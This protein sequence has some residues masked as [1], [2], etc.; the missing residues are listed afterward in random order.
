MELLMSDSPNRALDF[1]TGLLIG[2]LLAVGIGGSYTYAKIRDALAE[3]ERARS[4]EMKAREEAEEARFTE[5]AQHDARMHAEY[6]FDKV[7]R[8]LESQENDNK[9]MDAPEMPLAQDPE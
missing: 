4:A 8:R 7:L 3:A 5:Q 1:S 6:K 2:I 9:P